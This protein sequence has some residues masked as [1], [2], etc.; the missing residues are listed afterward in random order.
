MEY[1][2]IF[3]RNFGVF[4]EKQQNLLKN[5]K[6]L[7]VGNGGIGG[8]AANCF[9]RSGV[10]NFILS[11]FDVYEPSNLNRQINSD[12]DTIGRNK[13]D[14]TAE[15]LRSINP[16]INC[17][18]IPAKMS[19]D[20]IEEKL[21]SCTFVFPAADDFAFSLTVFRIAQNLGIPAL[22]VVPSG[23]W[24]R[25][26]IIPPGKLHVEELFG[27]PVFKSTGYT[28]LYNRLNKLVI[29]EMYK[30]A[31]FLYRKMV[32][33][34]RDYYKNFVN[35]KVSPTQICSLVWLVTSAGVNE[36]VKYITK[37]GKAVTL[38]SFLEITSGSIKKRNLKIISIASIR[39]FLSGKYIKKYMKSKM[40]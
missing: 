29:P 32:S 20:E 3:K 36:S 16:S 21:R 19:F 38:P 1:N 10:E 22:V 18:V 15:A 26:A 11:D 13:S 31:N 14:V 35:G 24:G 27:I 5:S 23:M 17:E 9:A 7:I 34:R 33:C 30:N 6:I 25:I 28:E 8:F 40:K 2:K 12:I 37:K 4:S 39:I